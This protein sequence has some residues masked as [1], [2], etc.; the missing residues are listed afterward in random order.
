MTLTP[1][2]TEAR[3]TRWLKILLFWQANIATPALAAN[4]PRETD[5]LRTIMV[6]LLRAVQGI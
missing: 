6:K 4:D 1:Q 5:S 3:R 2:G